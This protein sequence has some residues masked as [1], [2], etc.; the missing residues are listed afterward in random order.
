MLPKLE[1]EYMGKRFEILRNET[2]PN[3]LFLRPSEVTN[4]KTFRSNK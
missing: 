4:F 2:A 3:T 1:L